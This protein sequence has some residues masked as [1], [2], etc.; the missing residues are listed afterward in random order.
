MKK[1]I[2]STLALVATLAL[3]ACNNEE[4]EAYKMVITP[5]GAPTVTFYQ[6]ALDGHLETRDTPSLV[7]AELQEDRF[8]VVVCDL[9]SGLNSIIENE[10][11][12]KLARMITGGNLYLVGIDHDEKDNSD[13]PT[14]D[15]YIVNFGE[16]SLPSVVYKFLFPELVDSTHY[17]NAVA[18]AGAV[19]KTHLNEGETVDYV[20][21][22]QPVL[23]NIM[24]GLSE[25][26]QSAR[27]VICCL[28]DTWAEVTGQAAVIPQAGLFI[29]QTMYKKH[30]SY[31]EGFLDELD[32]QITT[33]IEDPALMKS[34]INEYSTDPT[35]QSALF[36][37]TADVAYAVQTYESSPNGF[38]LVTPEEQDSLDIQLFME[39]LGYETDYSSCLM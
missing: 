38:A 14:A 19:L 11:D 37:F 1:G 6:Q 31:F 9:T 13:M 23:Y 33:C 5:S 7:V 12:Y 39:T 18:D 17:V 2:L 3:G 27:H 34:K 21:V 24:S 15:D 20:L 10:A 28:R 4:D 36:G 25:E 8:G 32:D 26:E 30:K 35:E 16:T 29:N 22:A